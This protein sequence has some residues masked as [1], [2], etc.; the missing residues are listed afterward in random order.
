MEMFEAIM[1]RKSVRNY[2]DKQVEKDKLEKIVDAGNRAPN[3]GPFRLTVIT[4]K[5][6]L[7]AINDDALAAMRNSGNDFL[8]SRAAIPGYQPLYGAP[9][10]ILVSAP[11]GGYGIHNVAAA[12]AVM[13][14]AAA[15]LGLGSCYVVT[16]TLA[17]DGRNELS[18]RLALPEGY[19]PGCGVLVGYAGADS[20]GV[21]REAAGNVNWI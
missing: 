1:A 12:A 2:Q 5:T 10:L 19:V 4:D 13:T 6:Y 3:A 15:G 8:M 21:Q 17:L 9:A 20:L 14:I 16:P 18:K 7:K 11:A